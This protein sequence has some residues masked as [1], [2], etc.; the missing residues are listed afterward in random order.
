MDPDYLKPFS[1][2][3]YLLLKTKSFKKIRLNWIKETGNAYI[4]INIQKS[5]YSKKIYLNWGIYLKSLVEKPPTS[6]IGV[7][8][9]GRLDHLV[10]QN[11]LN[12]E[13][14]LPMEE[15]LDMIEQ[16]IRNNPYNL[17]TLDG[18]NNS[19]IKLIRDSGVLRISLKTKQYLKI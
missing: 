15:R 9:G 6:I 2:K 10:D 1:D 19:I 14:K 17:L 11:L 18:T 7:H 13:N 5:Y 4:V 12:F 8:I 16:L 3:L